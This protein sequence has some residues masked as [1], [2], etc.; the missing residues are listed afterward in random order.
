MDEK[1]DVR[2]GLN[3]FQNRATAE[4]ASADTLELATVFIG[5]LKRRC[6]LWKPTPVALRDAMQG[7]GI[8]V[9]INRHASQET[10]RAANA[11]VNAI[12]DMCPS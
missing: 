5:V 12:A 8:S 9:E 6:T 11:L 10:V 4:P 7:T 1:I 2:Y 3:P